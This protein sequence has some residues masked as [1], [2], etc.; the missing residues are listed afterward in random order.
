MKVQ[1]AVTQQGLGRS[2]REGQAGSQRLLFHLV[3]AWLPL[4]SHHPPCSPGLHP[5][6]C[7]QTC[8]W[9]PC[10]V[11]SYDHLVCRAT[12]GQSR[13]LGQLILCQV[14]SIR[15]AVQVIAWRLGA[16]TAVAGFSTWDREDGAERL[17]LVERMCLGKAWRLVG[18]QNLG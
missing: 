6:G 2:G 16:A 18:E 5:L 11:S 13:S 4:W 12:E 17:L 1:A 15:G 10:R 8:P 9:L 7:A 3:S 14:S